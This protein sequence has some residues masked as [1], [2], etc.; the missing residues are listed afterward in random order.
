MVIMLYVNIGRCVAV[1]FVLHVKKN[2]FV[3]CVKKPL[4][5]V[6]K[7][8]FVRRVKKPF[9]SRVKNLCLSCKKKHP[10]P[11]CKKNICPLCKKTPLS[12]VY[13]R[14]VK[15]QSKLVHLPLDVNYFIESVDYDELFTIC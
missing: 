5:L 2:T 13:G 10:C 9:V 11:S 12:V 15:F 4:S 14:E 1:T 8:T 7:N 3:R 6:Y